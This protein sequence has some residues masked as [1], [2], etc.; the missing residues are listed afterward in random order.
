MEIAFKNSFLKAIKKLR[1]KSLKD[2]IFDAINAAEQ[3][4]GLDDIPNIKKL[5]GYTVYY[6]IRICFKILF[7]FHQNSKISIR[8]SLLFLYQDKKSNKRKSRNSETRLR[9]KQRNFKNG[10]LILF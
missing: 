1:D 6:R 7:G 9:L 4:E 3:A 5:K 10:L 8:H 2:D